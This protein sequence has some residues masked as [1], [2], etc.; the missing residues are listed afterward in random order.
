MRRNLTSSAILITMG[1]LSSVQLFAELNRVE[2]FQLGVGLG[3]P[4]QVQYVF[5][6]L[7]QAPVGITVRPKLAPRHIFP[8]SHLHSDPQDVSIHRSG[9]ECLVPFFSGELRR[10][11]SK[12]A[13]SSEGRRAEAAVNPW[14]QVLSEEHCLP[15][16][17][18]EP[19]ERWELARLARWRAHAAGCWWLV[20]M[21]VSD[22]VIARW[23]GGG[24]PDSGGG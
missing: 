7:A 5:F 21:G 18:R 12:A 11:S 6:A 1:R 15:A 8:A 22:A 13:R 14:R 19:V 20:V 4:D 23:R 17:V 3:E 10:W 2:R 24:R 9:G 16:G